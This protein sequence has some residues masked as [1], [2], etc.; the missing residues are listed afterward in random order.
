MNMP[1]GNLPVPKGGAPSMGGEQEQIDP[2]QLESMLT[3]VLGRV[4]AIAD[5]NGLDFNALVSSVGGGA[6]APMSAPPM[7]AGGAPVPPM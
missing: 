6:P 5:Q 4:K 3:E 2:A 1:A 7:P